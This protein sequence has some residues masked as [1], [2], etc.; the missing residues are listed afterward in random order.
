[1]SS[2][3]FLQQVTS[4]IR[5]KEARSYVEEELKHHLTQSTQ[6]W[7]NKG[8]SPIEA[9]EK[10]IA[11]MGSASQ[12]GK[13]MDKLHRPKWDFWLIGAVLLL[14]AA[15]FAPILTTDFTQPYGP[16]MTGYFVKN[17]IIHILLAIA[18]IAAIMYFDYRKLQRYSLLIYGGA[19]LL[20]FVLWFMPNGFIYGKAVYQIGPVRF[21]AWMALPLLLVAFAGFFTERKWKGWQLTGFILA[22][23]YLFMKLSNLTVTLLYVGV[24]AVLFS[25]SYFS[26]K[27]KLY[28]CLAVGSILMAIAAFS[29]YAY[30]YVGV[31]Y[32]TVRIAAFL[33]PELYADTAGYVILQLKKA[34]AGASWFG[35]GTNYYVP[36]AHTDYALVQLIQSYG[37]VAGIAI[38]TMM[39]VVALRILWLVRTMPQSFGKLLVLGAVTLYSCQSIYSIFMVFGILPI[40]SMPLPFISYGTISILLNAILIGLVLSVYRRKAYIGKQVFSV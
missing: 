35:A 2:K 14:I 36:E 9:E 33:H 1:M 38:I 20:L 23:L 4:H 37:Y 40:I 28:V 32:Q 16:N 6:G 7:V 5:S 15:S 18:G 25:F 13:S 3:Q 11:E 34:L 39:L 17:K 10:A 12:L 21:H 30:H 29:V 31:S 8:Y 26:R 22:P 19:L 24:V 27:V